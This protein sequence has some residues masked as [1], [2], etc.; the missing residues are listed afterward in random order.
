M[1]HI[2]F[3]DDCYSIISAADDRDT[4]LVRI[5]SNRW[6]EDQHYRTIPM[7]CYSSIDG[8]FVEIKRPVADI[9]IT[10]C[11]SIGVHELINNEDHQ[12]MRSLAGTP[13]YES[14]FMYWLYRNSSD[15]VRKLITNQYDYSPPK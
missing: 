6:S 10:I 4:E 15:T 9:M 5:L 8:D 3:Y 7:M 12:L 14:P 11:D 1:A 13:L 2:D